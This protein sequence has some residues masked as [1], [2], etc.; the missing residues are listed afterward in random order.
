MKVKALMTQTAGEERFL[1]PQEWEC[2]S[3]TQSALPNVCPDPI[4]P[5]SWAIGTKP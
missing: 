1:S 4:T 5:N 3:L 2:L